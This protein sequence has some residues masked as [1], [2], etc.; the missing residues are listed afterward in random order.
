MKNNT[1]VG[2]IAQAISPGK[3]PPTA[4]SRTREMPLL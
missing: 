3:L 2:T 4:K 1:I